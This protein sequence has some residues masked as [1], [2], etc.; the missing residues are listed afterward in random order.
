ME[1]KLK[2]LLER[3]LILAKDKALLK[4]KMKRNETARNKQITLLR[5]PKESDGDANQLKLKFFKCSKCNNIYNNESGL[6]DHKNAL[7]NLSTDFSCTF[8]DESFNSMSHLQEH[9]IS[10][11]CT[12]INNDQRSEKTTSR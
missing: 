6:T 4:I 7:H 5:K 8:C 3:T 1:K 12:H 9:T 11:H 2:A 10:K